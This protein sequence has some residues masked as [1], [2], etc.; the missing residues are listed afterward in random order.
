[1]EGT[2]GVINR[3]LTL[4]DVVCILHIYMYV[5]IHGILVMKE[6]E[7]MPFAM[8]WMKLVENNV[9]SELENT[10]WYHLYVEPKKIIQMNVYTKQK[11]IYRKHTWVTKGERSWEGTS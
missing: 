11:Q 5:Y 10:T 3:W 7:I 2:Q 9:I 4:E 8:M 1:M 6:N